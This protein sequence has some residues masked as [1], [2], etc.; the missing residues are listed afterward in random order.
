MLVFIIKWQSLRLTD[1]FGQK[2]FSWS[3]VKY[4]Y[5]PRKDNVNVNKLI[6]VLTLMETSC[7]QGH[8]T[9]VAWVWFDD[10]LIFPCYKALHIKQI[11]NVF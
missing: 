10:Q 2:Y 8:I 7:D 9:K 3:S 5:Q 1:L 6:E 11:V 4:L